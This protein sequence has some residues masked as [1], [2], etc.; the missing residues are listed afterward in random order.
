NYK[1]LVL[2]NMENNKISD[3][4]NISDFLWNPKEDILIAT[5]VNQEDEDAKL[6]KIHPLKIIK[7]INECHKCTYSQIK[8]SE[9][10]DYLIY[11]KKNEN[12][13]RQIHF[14]NENGSKKVLPD[15][16]VNK[17]FPGY[18]IEDWY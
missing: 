5:K 16:I 6:L 7:T 18:Q 15:S 17:Q 13:N 1:T 8:W 4:S 3:F 14:V 10:G 2:K 12:E 11:L 9:Y